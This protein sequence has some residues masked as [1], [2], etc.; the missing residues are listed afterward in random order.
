MPLWMTTAGVGSDPT[1]ISTLLR[2]SSLAKISPSAQR[3]ET[4][5]LPPPVAPREP[6]VHPE[7]DERL[8]SKV[9]PVRERGGPVM[10]F[11]DDDH[12]RSLA[13]DRFDRRKKEPA[14]VRTRQPEQ[15]VDVVGIHLPLCEPLLWAVSSVV[16]AKEPC[17]V[18]LDL[19]RVSHND[20][21][22][23]AAEPLRMRCAQIPDDLHDG[24]LR[25]SERGRNMSYTH[26]GHAWWRGRR[27]A[28]LAR[29]CRESPGM[30]RC[31]SSTRVP[32]VARRVPQPGR[33]L[34]VRV[35]RVYHAGRSGAQNARERA[36]VALGANVTL[37]VPSA[38]PGPEDA[39]RIVE[40]R[41]ELV[42]LEVVRAGDVNRHRYQDPSML[43]R[44]IA[45]VRPDLLDVHEE[46]FSVAARQWLR[47]A[48]A[49]LPIV[50]YTAQN[51]D[52][53]FPPPF[54]GYERKALR[55]VIGLYPCS[56][57]AASVARA[58]G[59][60]GTVRV[61]PLGFDPALFRP[62]RQSLDDPEVVLGAVRAPRAR[63][64]R[65]RRR[66]MYLPASERCARPV[67][68]SS[69][70]GRRHELPFR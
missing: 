67:S 26:G 58:K 10:A 4:A 15:A 20:Q 39:E 70:R 16:H 36:L 51:I 49:D 5:E 69:G 48:P 17:V 29:Q 46:P 62:G 33:Q 11:V 57:Q 43:A 50:M 23:F 60:A 3:E 35:M 45:D 32:T 66:S 61:I 44:A 13:K 56:R 59:F 14:A 55:R 52:K 21:R 54:S 6:D 65:R 53:R 19:A 30:H 2:R 27:Q 42:E 18:E 9:S 38:W 25:R 28:P 40:S 31:D 22:I 1:R 63:E 41:F 12:C 24:A 8:R 64:G 37:V 47:A 34:D 68:S 7:H